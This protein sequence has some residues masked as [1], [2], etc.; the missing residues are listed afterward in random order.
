MSM[1]SRST[2]V[3][4]RPRSPIAWFGPLITSIQSSKMLVQGFQDLIPTLF[5]T[6]KPL[7]A[8]RGERLVSHPLVTRGRGAS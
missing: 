7:A 6:R 4:A 1:L 2:L 3:L 5:N 8:F